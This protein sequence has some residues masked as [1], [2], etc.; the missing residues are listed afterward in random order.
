LLHYD[1][2]AAAHAVEHLGF[3]KLNLQLARYWLSRWKNG[4]P[5]PRADIRPRDVKAHLPGIAIMELHDNGSVM[6]RLAG[7]ALAMGLGIDPTAWTSSRSR[8]RNFA[9]RACRAIAASPTA[10]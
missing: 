7:S 4:A 6:C 10:R 8:R 5:P 1:E 9:K 2:V 3:G